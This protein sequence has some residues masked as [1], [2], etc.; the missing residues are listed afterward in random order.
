MLQQLVVRVLI[1]LLQVIVCDRRAP[2]VR[3]IALRATSFHRDLVKALSFAAPE[4]NFFA[5]SKLRL[6]KLELVVLGTLGEWCQIEVPALGG[7]VFLLG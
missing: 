1:D 7:H 2:E 5:L 6:A 3:D 4:E